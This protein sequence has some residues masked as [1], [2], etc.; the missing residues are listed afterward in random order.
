[1]ANWI[2]FLIKIVRNRKN[3]PVSNSYEPDP[4]SSN[5]MNVYYMLNIKQHALL[6]LD[7][8]LALTCS[9]SRDL[10]ILL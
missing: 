4:F 6:E 3:I 5:I 8:S 9:K 7:C 2:V 10:P 1:M